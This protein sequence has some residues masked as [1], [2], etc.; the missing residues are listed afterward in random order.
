[1][2]FVHAF[3]VPVGQP[4]C[5]RRYSSLGAWACRLASGRAPPRPFTDDAGRRGRRRLSLRF[6]P[7]LLSLFAAAASTLLLELDYVLADT[8]D[9]DVWWLYG[10]DADG[11]RALMA[12]IVGSMITVVSIVFSI[13]IVSLT[14]ASTQFGSRL[15]RTFMRTAAISSSSAPSSR[16]SS[17]ACS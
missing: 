14:L 15:L 7:A 9:V 4:R 6:V 3:A 1:M 17:T 10:G 16:P 2:R 5:A 11:A 13:T 8:I 12:T